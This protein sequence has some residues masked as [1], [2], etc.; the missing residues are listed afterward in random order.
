MAKNEHLCVT[1][2][3]ILHESDNPDQIK[4]MFDDRIRTYVSANSAN[5]YSHLR[6]QRETR[7]HHRICNCIK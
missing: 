5:I 2:S 3:H 1:K 7:P 6:I 4:K